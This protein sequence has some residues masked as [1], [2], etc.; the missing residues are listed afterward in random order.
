MDGQSSHLP[1]GTLWERAD[2]IPWGA[3]SAFADAVV[4]D[5]SIVD[6][7]LEAYDE[8]LPKREVEERYVD[9]YVPA[10]FAMAAPRLPDDQRVRIGE[11]LI[12]RLVEAGR[13]QDELDEDSLV[14]ACGS[15]GPVV[16]PAV[17]AAIERESDLT[18]AWFDL[19]RLTELVV[20][21]EDVEIREK[22]AQACVSVLEKVDRGEIESDAGMGAAWTLGWLQRVEYADLLDRLG[23]KCVS[24]LG[25]ADYRE[26]ARTL[27]AGRLP[28]AVHRPWEKPVDE[29]LT[30]VWR[31][32]KD[33]FSRPHLEPEEP[34]QVEFP[35]GEG[36]SLEFSETLFEP[37]VPIVNVAP[38]VGRNEPCPCGSGKKYKKCCGRTSQDHTVSG[39]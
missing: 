11:A 15:M 35:G 33:W 37:P 38:K 24:Y 30:P 9:L 1:W 8:S 27:R 17:L 39:V 13:I 25:G 26:A 10:I 21:T 22:V 18:G 12:E 16:L 2:E 7:L 29:W 4:A 6:K 23:S 36:E 19:W 5:A 31:D 32:V 34:S 28:L 14:A 20:Q 3:L